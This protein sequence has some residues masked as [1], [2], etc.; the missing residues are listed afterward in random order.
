MLFQYVMQPDGSLE[1]PFVSQGCRDIYEAEPEMLRNNPL[2]PSERVHPDDRD[3]HDRSIAVS[4]ETLSPWRCEYR[5]RLESGKTKWLQGA[6]RPQRLPDGGI[7]WDGLLTDITAR[8]E[9]ETERDRFFTLSL[10]ML[11]I[12]GSDGYFKRVNPAWEATL[13]FSSDEMMAVPFIE[14]VHPDDIAATTKEDAELIR[15]GELMGFENRYRCRDGSYKWLLWMCASFEDLIYCVAH[16]VT[17]AK[18]AEKALHEAN[19]D[20]EARVEERTT[21]LQLEV[22]ERQRVEQEVRAQARQHQAVAELGRQALLNLDLETLFQD[23]VGLISATLEVE[24]CSFWERLPASDTLRLRASMG[25]SASKKRQSA[26]ERTIGDDSHLGYSA[27]IQEPVISEDLEHET[28]FGRS[29]FLR[30]HGVLS[31]IAMPVYDGELYGML[32]ACSI[33][34]KKFGQNEIYFL[35]MVANVLSSAIARKQTEAENFQ[36]NLNLQAANEELRANEARLLQGNQ[37]STDLMR[38]RVRTDDELREALQKITESASRMLDVERSSIW[39]FDQNGTTLCCQD[40]F[41]RAAHRHSNGAELPEDENYFP[42]IKAQREVVADDAKT[43]PVTRDLLEAYLETNRVASLLDV[44]LV[45]G[46]K[47][48]GVLCCEHVGTPRQWQAEDRTFASAIASVCSLVLE[49][50]E[51]TRAEIALQAAKEEAE[52]AT[53]EANTANLAKSEFLSR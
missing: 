8:K 37:I 41:E 27:F 52:H 24:I 14:F 51:R 35:R 48:I 5:I 26:P 40:L 21:K 34:K 2:W 22:L 12:I 18:E 44:A 10:D 16:D 43:N 49:S 15:G 39:L 23:A 47:H 45:M 20:L 4:A 50:Y 29:P 30:E 36:L 19:E 11:A 1:L 42:A 13:G 31:A 6:G 9:A 38:L 46:G 17:H 33:D 25:E 32:S 53:E 7:L 28:R 3:A